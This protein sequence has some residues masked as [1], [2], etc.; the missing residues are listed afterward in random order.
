M[1]IY[2]DD[3]FKKINYGI[4]KSINNLIIAIIKKFANFYLY[5]K[6]FFNFVNL[7]ILLSI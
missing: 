1:I 7:K 6:F 4:N 2:I 5:I 3:I